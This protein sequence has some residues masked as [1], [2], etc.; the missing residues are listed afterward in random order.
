M[1]RQQHGRE[2]SEDE[3]LADSSK[4]ARWNCWFP[5]DDVELPYSPVTRKNG[6]QEKQDKN[7]NKG[8]D[9]Y[10]PLRQLPSS[11]CSPP[12]SSLNPFPACPTLISD[13]H[14]P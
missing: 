13:T 4:S 1:K 3:K 7:K 8:S 14:D 9:G 12:D 10:S 2:G 6:L 11:K 5:I